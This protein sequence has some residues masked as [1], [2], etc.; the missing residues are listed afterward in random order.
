MTQRDSVA[1]PP[2][3]V[4][5]TPKPLQYCESYRGCTASLNGVSI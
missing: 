2:H 5:S 3:R 4:C 1:V